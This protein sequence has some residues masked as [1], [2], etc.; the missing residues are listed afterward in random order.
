VT[1]VLL[2]VA[3]MDRGWA[4]M[5]GPRETKV[6]TTESGVRVTEMGSEVSP[7]ALP[8]G[9]VCAGLGSGVGAGWFGREVW[10]LKR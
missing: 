2:V 10:R 4:V 9:L 5:K 8:M 1:I 3:G 6:Y 7:Y